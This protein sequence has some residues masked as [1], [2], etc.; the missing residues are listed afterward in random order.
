MS[1]ARSKAAIW[2]GR[3][4]WLGILANLGAAIPTLLVP[5]RLIAM[6]NLPA[7]TPLV[8]PRFAAWL[9]I[10]LSL[11]YMPGAMDVDKYRVTAKR[12]VFSRLAGVVFFWLTQ[13]SEYRM[14][15]TFDFVFLV[16]ETILLTVALRQIRAIEKGG[17]A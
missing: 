2:F 17:L 16:P 1:M 14:F 15:G 7:A 10:L 11:F 4:V 8:W 12:S 6:L 5:D 13:P 3:V 9:L